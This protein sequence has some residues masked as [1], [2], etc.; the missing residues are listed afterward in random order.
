MLT[1]PS[2]KSGDNKKTHTHTHTLWSQ[3][4]SYRCLCRRVST[5]LA[6]FLCGGS[7][8]SV[9]WRCVCACVRA[10][11]CM[12]ACV[13]LHGCGVFFWLIGLSM[14]LWCEF[15]GMYIYVCTCML[16]IV[17][18]TGTPPPHLKMVVLIASYDCV[19]SP[20][21]LLLWVCVFC[22]SVHSYTAL[23]CHSV[24]WLAHVRA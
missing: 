18:D 3:H 20:F 9:C 15:I 13:C 11:V 16:S 17:A 7:L 8:C 14:W 24:H 23:V 4:S 1:F 10:C 19:H 12:C 22:A 21:F 5:Q 2:K 6:V